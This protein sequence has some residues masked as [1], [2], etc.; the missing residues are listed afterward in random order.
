MH[1]AVDVKGLVTLF[2]KADFTK[3]DG[4]LP[5]NVRFGNFE[6]SLRKASVPLPSWPTRAGLFEFEV[7]VVVDILISL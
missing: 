1:V 4:E 3:Y 5:R 2:C 6:T 7:D